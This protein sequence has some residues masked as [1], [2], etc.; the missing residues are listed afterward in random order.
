[1][2]SARRSVLVL[3]F[4]IEPAQQLTFRPDE[5]GLGRVPAGHAPARATIEGRMA[6]P[7]WLVEIIAVAAH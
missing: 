3:L 1:L 7:A 2:I 4:A 5:Q 6:N